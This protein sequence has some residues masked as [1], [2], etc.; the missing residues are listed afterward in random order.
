M[1]FKTFLLWDKHSQHFKIQ[2]ILQQVVTGRIL[3]PPEN[4]YLTKE[5]D[6]GPH[7]FSKLT[8]LNDEVDCEGA[9]LMP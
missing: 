5:L 2:A 7:L 9:F 6:N 1:V 8:P 3:K 4:N